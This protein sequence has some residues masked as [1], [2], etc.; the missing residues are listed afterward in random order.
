MTQT[1]P[2]FTVGIEEEYLLVD[3]ETRALVVDPPKSLM[4][5]CEARLEGRVSPEFLKS[6]IEVGTSKCATLAEAAEEIRHLRRCVA[7]VAGR[8]GL[9]PI[10]AL[11]L[12]LLR[13]LY[14]L[15]R[16]NQRWRVY[17]NMLVQENRWRA[18][19]YGFDEGL[20]DFGRG[21][22]VPYAD[23]LEELIELTW[24]DA[25]QFGCVEQIRHAR[26]ILARGTSAHRQLAV[27]AK[28]VEA[29]AAP[30]AALK[31]VVDFLIAE[32]VEGL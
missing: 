2:S 14:R 25:E 30:Q 3:L 13:M 21:E 31:A 17:N 16:S 12:C 6:Q 29:G 28:S 24:D 18:Q 26:D 7:E 20:V 10:A 32:T 19:R 22:I 15:K 11:Y 23:L 1:E 27:Y 4:A 5:E 8:H 9:A